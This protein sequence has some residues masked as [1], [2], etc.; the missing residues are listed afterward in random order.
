M[1]VVGKLTSCAAPTPSCN[2]NLL[3]KA[4]HDDFCPTTQNLEINCTPRPTDPPYD[5][6]DQTRDKMDNPKIPIGSDIN[7]EKYF[8]Y[9]KMARELAV[10]KATDSDTQREQMKQ[11]ITQNA[12]DKQFVTRFTSMVVVEND[13]AR[14][15]R[16]SDVRTKVKRSAEFRDELAQLFQ[17]RAVEDLKIIERKRRTAEE[18]SQSESAISAQLL[19]PAFAIAFVLRLVRRPVRNFLGKFC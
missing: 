9:L 14:K 3:V 13:N 6:E 1:V 2:N 5:P 16:A 17:Q 18:F 11:D 19:L 4:S 12:V 10:Y 8:A 7:L 15:R